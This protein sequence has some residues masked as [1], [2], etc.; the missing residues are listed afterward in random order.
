MFL[1]MKISFLVSLLI[2]QDCRIKIFFFFSAYCLII[3]LMFL[4]VSVTAL[5]GKPD[6]FGVHF[7]FVPNEVVMML[8]PLLMLQWWK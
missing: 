5:E 1:I 6:M 7:V 8:S 4:M 2:Y 3:I